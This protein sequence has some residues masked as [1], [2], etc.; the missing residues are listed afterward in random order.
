[1]DIEWRLVDDGRPPREGMGRHVEYFLRV[2]Q[3]S[4]GGGVFVLGQVELLA[5]GFEGLDEGVVALGG[6]GDGVGRRE[7]RHELRDGAVDPFR[8]EGGWEL[9]WVHEEECRWDL[10]ERQM[11]AARGPYGTRLGAR[12]HPWD[13]SGMSSI[14][15]GTYDTKVTTK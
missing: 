12:R 4:G 1:M 7:Q 3:S 10:D 13:S 15:R 11:A 14:Q 8:G 5:N 6:V 2:V 9:G